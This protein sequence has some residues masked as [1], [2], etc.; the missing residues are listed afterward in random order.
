MLQLDAANRKSYPGSGTAWNDLS[1]IGNN[2]TLTN[3]PAYTSANSGYFTFDGTNDYTSIASVNGITN[4]T[5]ANNYSIDLWCYINST[6]NN[7]VNSYNLI[8]WKWNGAGN[9]LYPYNIAYFRNTDTIVVG[10]ADNISINSI[11][12]TV[13]TNA[14]L[15][16]CPVFDWSSSSLRLYVNGTLRSSTTLSLAGSIEN[17]T[18]TQLMGNSSNFVPATGNLSSFKIYNRALSATEVQQNFNALRGRYNI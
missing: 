1:G 8:V 16:I 9:A 12:T 7:T 2:G 18:N 4:F 3:S 13:S 11:S 6:Q 5:K 17:N 10:A 14:W 15:N